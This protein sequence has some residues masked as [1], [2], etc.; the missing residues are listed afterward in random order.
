[1]SAT[2]P[3]P[4]L[5]ITDPPPTPTDQF[6]SALASMSPIG[7]LLSAIAGPGEDARA[8]L[9]SL[10]L[11]LIEEGRRFATTASGQR[12]IGLLEDSPAVTNGWLLWNQANIDYHLRNATP[13]PDGPVAMLDAVLQELALSDTAALVG[14]LSRLAAE[15]ES[16][17][18]RGEIT[19]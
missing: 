5:V 14:Q 16:A 7:A 12:W 3:I 11:S 15:V 13:M 17:N 6:A 19:P 18:G 2:A 10:V 1:M 4:R 9:K 8:A